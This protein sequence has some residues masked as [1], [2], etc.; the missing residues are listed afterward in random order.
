M[1][2]VGAGVAAMGV[3]AAATFAI[4]KKATTQPTTALQAF[5]L[6]CQDVS[7]TRAWREAQGRSGLGCRA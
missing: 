3:A 6:A 1:L 7:D 4:A 5:E 2:A